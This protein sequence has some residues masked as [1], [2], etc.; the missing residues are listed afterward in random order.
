MADTTALVH[1]GLRKY[2]NAESRFVSQ[3]K[4]GR[5]IYKLAWAVEILAA[6]IG[7]S[8]AW[9]TGYAAFYEIKNPEFMDYVNAMTGALPFVIIAIIEPTKIPLAAGFY[10]AKVWRWKFLILLALIAL[11]GVT[12][13]TMF[14]GLERNLSNVTLTIQG[15]KNHIRSLDDK[16]ATT[17]AE[18]TGLENAT[19][20]LVNEKHTQII[21]EQIDKRDIEI[22]NIQKALDA[23]TSTL[24]QEMNEL[25]A[26]RPIVEITDL[27]KNL[28]RI[29]TK[30]KNLEIQRDNEIELERKN[31]SSSINAQ[32]AALQQK[33]KAKH[34]QIADINKQM[35]ASREVFDKRFQEGANS[36]FG[37]TAKA[38][39]DYKAETE[40]FEKQKSDLNAEI[41]EFTNL[42]GD[43]A[44]GVGPV[45]LEAIGDIRQ[46]YQKKI[47]PL[48]KEEAKVQ[49]QRDRLSSERSGSVAKKMEALK[50]QLSNIE[51]PLL[52]R[53][54][55]I[56]A[57]YTKRISD[58][59]VRKSEELEQ[60]A[61]RKK[62]IPA[63]EQKI[64]GWN[65]ERDE[66]L[67]V[68]RKK[69]QQNQVYRLAAMFYSL[70]DPALVT[71]EQLKTVAFIWFG[72][73]A[74]ITATI[75]TV[76]AIVSFVLQDP[77]A[78]VVRRHASLR[79]LLFTIFIRLSRLLR[80]ILLAWAGFFDKKLLNAFRMM[81][82]GIRRHFHK[83]RTKVVKVEVEVE[84]IVEKEVEVTVEKIV[85]KEVP[86]EIVRKELVYVPLY[87]TEQGLLNTDTSLF[88][89]KPPT[90]DPTE[91]D[92]SKVDEDEGAS[93]SD[94]DSSTQEDARDG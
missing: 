22:G 62:I 48:T 54:E 82:V 77:E 58:M 65:Q 94:K 23:E 64:G 56:V 45:L 89:K 11:T 6:F 55:G 12:F 26:G 8:I 2:L 40:S 61:E 7:L 52:E 32:K 85:Y 71:T 19:E 42:L 34:G 49:K 31:N 80:A 86:K 1:Q 37:S 20:Q 5:F 84:K 93:P 66:S 67:D 87:S 15:E 79:T 33:I 17:R 69:S 70:E 18:L 81:A 76:L 39:K 51:K 63:L 14:N 88:T 4:Y 75:G 53:R 3:K 73:I 29:E 35:A 28:E 83:P 60:L 36:F 30:I 13:E 44:T 50:A 27:D 24:R 78:F 90:E 72:S 10:S 16:I 91:E 43:S 57:D 46:R 74:F 68:K 21:D 25:V 41:S 38:E 92:P 47:A 59:E 9:L